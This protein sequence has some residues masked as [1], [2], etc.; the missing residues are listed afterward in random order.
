MT[1]SFRDS[2]TEVAF[3]F[4]LGVSE[5]R[6]QLADETA[7]RVQLET[8]LAAVSN[9][10]RYVEEQKTSHANRIVELNSLNSKLRKQ[11]A[12]SEHQFARKTELANKFLG[13]YDR[14]TLGL[15]YLVDELES[16]RDNA[17]T[18]AAAI[19]LGHA[20]AKLLAVYSPPRE[21]ERTA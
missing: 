2:L 15:S 20:V 1:D 16:A 10:L 13:D 8:D 4:G 3:A 18:K 17:K 7:K 19:A 9:S 14:I 5:L 21:D 12:D 11:L 6:K